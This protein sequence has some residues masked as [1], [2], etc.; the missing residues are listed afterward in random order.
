MLAS[1]SK[2][3][4]PGCEVSQLAAA[5][6]LLNIKAQFSMLERAYNLISEWSHWCGPAETTLPH[7]MYNMKKLV[8]GLGL[9]VQKDRL[10][11]KWLHDFL[12]SE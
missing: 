10:L 7:N 1:A 8:E 2:P 5:T 3:L 6:T 4:Y 11:Q 9:Q 12:G